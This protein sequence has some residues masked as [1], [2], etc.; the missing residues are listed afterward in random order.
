MC[1]TGTGCH[2]NEFEC[3]SKNQCIPR[4]F[5]CDKTN[6]C[7][8][9]SDEVGCC[10]LSNIKVYTKSAAAIFIKNLSE[11]LFINVFV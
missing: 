8:D 11:S 10:K 3:F 7:Q 2:V 5:H 1:A 4:H 9:G 6:D